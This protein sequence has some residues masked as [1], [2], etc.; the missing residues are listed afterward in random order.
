MDE[1]SEASDRDQIH[2]YVLHIP[3]LRD[4]IIQEF[5]TVTLHTNP[6]QFRVCGGDVYIQYNIVLPSFL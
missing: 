2:S 6:L 3:W 5:L 4:L 1:L